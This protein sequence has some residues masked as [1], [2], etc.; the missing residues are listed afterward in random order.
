MKRSIGAVLAAVGL[1]TA[2]GALAQ[3][4][5]AAPAAKPAPARQCFWVNQVNGF[6][7]PDDQTVYV[8]VAVHDV[9]E[10]K[11]FGPCPNV[12]WTQRIGV[13]PW[14]GMSNVCTGADLDL[15]VPQVGMSPMKCHVRAMRK[16][17]DDEA[18]A[19]RTSKKK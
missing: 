18:K 5:A 11:L 3:A 6:S 4:P 17:T 1:A 14:G 12:D 2:G 19:L 7:S 8:D 16:L 10:L 9:Y 15:I 13:K